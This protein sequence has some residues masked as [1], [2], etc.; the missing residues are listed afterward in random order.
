M[1]QERIRMLKE[2]HL[3]NPV[4]KVT[5]HQQDLPHARRALK[6]LKLT[7]KKE[8]HRAHSVL[9][10]GITTLLDKLLATPAAHPSIRRKK[11]RHSVSNVKGE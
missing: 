9:L 5:I 8:P 7:P 11:E 4:L 6:E 3:A 2:E 1:Q 10:G